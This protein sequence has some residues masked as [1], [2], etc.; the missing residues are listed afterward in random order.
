MINDNAKEMRRPEFH[1]KCKEAY[2]H[3]TGTEPYSPWK[4]TAERE[5]I[6]SSK[7]A[8]ACQMTA[9]GAPLRTWDW[10]LELESFIQFIVPTISTNS[11]WVMF[12]EP[13]ASEHGYFPKDARLL[14]K[15]LGSAIDTGGVMTARIMKGNGEVAERSTLRGLTP[16]EVVHQKYGAKTKDSD[17]GPDG[18]NLVKGDVHELYKEV[19]GPEFP[20]LDD[21][22]TDAQVTGGYLVNTEILIPTVAGMEECGKVIRRKGTAM[23]TPLMVPPIRIP[24]LTLACMKS[25]FQTDIP[26][27]LQQTLLLIS[28]MGTV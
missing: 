3:L 22:L 28:A 8:A 2:C 18:L 16:E 9:R 14:G 11:T 25:S 19:D 17:L 10:A 21:E 1:W 24:S 4:N 27:S 6:G 15:Y 20:E 12:R 5:I 23:V 13:K 26:K 7:K